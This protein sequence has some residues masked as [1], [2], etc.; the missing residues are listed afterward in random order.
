MDLRDVQSRRLA[1]DN[2]R[3][4]RLGRARLAALASL[5]AAVVITLAIVIGNTGGSSSSKH[6]SVAKRTTTK[7]TTSTNAAAS[8]SRTAVPILTYYVIN[9]PPPGSSAPADL[10]TP[11]DQ[12]ASQ[13]NALKAA[14]WHAVTLDQVQAYWSQGKSLGSGKPVV[15]SFDNGYASQYTNALP[16]LKGLGWPAVVNLQVN[17]LSPSQGGMS[18]SQI[19]GLLAAGWELDAEGVTHTDL[20]TV[21]TTQ[22]QSETT[23]A[24]QTLKSRYG[25]PVNWFC[26]PLGTYNDS[27][28]AA[29]RSAG[30][31]GASTIVP[32]WASSKED[33]FRLPRLQVAANTSSSQLLSQIAAAQNDGPPPSSSTRPGLA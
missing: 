4:Q 3:K 12:F 25:V 27:V 7:P 1:Q 14:G 10:Y 11:A 22:L 19:R 8:A 6:H 26:Y 15:I 30:Y 16:V 20:T 5:L 13:M 17:G 18:D 29:V 31:V 23:T 33:R 2:Q 32:G 21:G 28:V 24:R 9:S